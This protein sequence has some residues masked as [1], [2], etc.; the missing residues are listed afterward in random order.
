MVFKSGCIAMAFALASVVGTHTFAGEA[1]ESA[2]I[3]LTPSDVKWGE[4]PPMLPP[5]SKMAVLY[6]DPAKAGMFVIR[7]KMPAGYKIPAHSHPGDET[8]T[9]LS[10]IFMMG[11]GDKL[12]PKVAKPLPVGSF[13]MMPAKSNHFAFAKTA[14]VVQVVAMGPLAFDY[15]NPGED[16]RNAKA[17]PPPDK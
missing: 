8:V 16:P 10:G 3:L 17:T 7:A 11:M 2:H 12:D 13:A 14:S 5:G 1:G 9:V 15:V 6:G 4:P